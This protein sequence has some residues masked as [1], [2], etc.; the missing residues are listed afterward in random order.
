[1]P[2]EPSSRD[3]LQTLSPTKIILPILI[4]LGVVG[5]MLARN[6]NVDTF[7]NVN[8][9]WAMLWWIALAVLLVCFRH[10]LLMYRI[11]RLTEYQLNWWQSFNIISIWEFGSAATPSVVGGTA[12][13]LFL[14]TKEKIKAGETI[15]IVLFTIF[16]DG[17]FFILTVPILWLTVGKALLAPAY[18]NPELQEGIFWMYVFFIGY[19]FMCA[20]TVAIGYGL[21]V[22]P[23]SFRWFII[24]M[25][26]LP[27]LNRWQAQAQQTGD[28]IVFASAELKKKDRSFWLAGFWSTYSI[29]VIRFLILNC[30]MAA[31]LVVGSHLL[32]FGRQLMLYILM[33]L[34][35]TPG[36]SGLAEVAFDK[37]LA[38]FFTVE[39][40]GITTVNKGLSTIVV[41][42]WRLI[43]YYSYLI[44][45]VLVLPNWL[46]K[47]LGKRKES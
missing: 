17:L 20:Y 21:F 6:L 44:L 43:T 11:R 22:K 37:L 12:V 42:I 45:G 46:R 31:L 9:S 40:E 30:V 47:V 33:L 10:F 41:A 26:K 19:A 7:S 25:T 23:H 29:W 27:F 15:T 4:G 38:D 5:Y 1:M 34:P 35:L 39:K 13:A 28:D 3:I 14:L 16:L 36:G 32:L 8:W 18:A 24:K 2:S